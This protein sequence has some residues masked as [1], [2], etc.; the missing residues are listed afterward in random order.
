MRMHNSQSCNI[1]C[2]LSAFVI[3][4]LPQY[5]AL[6]YRWGIDEPSH[7][8]HIDGVPVRVQSNLHDY[9]QLL[10]NEAQHDWYFIDYLCINQSDIVERSHQVRLMRQ[11]YGCAS[12]VIAWMGT[13]ADI[14]PQV[15]ENE[16][17]RI[18]MLC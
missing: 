18:C 9:L 10:S 6:S 16:C 11:I 15:S 14:R 12:E 5:I 3:D 8:I 17:E 2:S 4:N 1:E 13:K 7:G